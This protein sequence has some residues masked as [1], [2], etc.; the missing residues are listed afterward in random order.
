MKTIYRSLTIIFS[1]LTLFVS[2]K[3]IA[4]CSILVTQSSTNV[5]AG[6]PVTLTAR[7]VNINAGTGANGS[8]TVSSTYHTDSIRSAVSGNNASGT[9]TITV[10][11]STGF[12]VGQEVLIITMVDP[13]TSGNL[14]GQY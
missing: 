2:Q 3:S 7:L 12:A 5:C 13:A 6:S 9:N 10:A 1:L 4:Q 14:V 11:S 8:I